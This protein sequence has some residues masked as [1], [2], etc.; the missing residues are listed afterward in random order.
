MRFSLALVTGA[1]SGIGEA[2]AYLLANKGIDLILH[3]RNTESLERV[4]KQIGGKVKVEWMTAD[5]AHSDERQKVAEV[6]R[7]KKP[8]LVINNAGFGLFGS[9]LESDVARQF[10]IAEVNAM[11]VL[12]L[13]LVAA[14]MMKGAELQGV[15]LNVSSSA[16]ELPI[17]PGFAVYSA[18]KAFVNKFS[19]SLD[20]EL[21]GSGIRVLASAPG[22]VNTNFSK[23]AG[24]NTRK[25]IHNITMTSDFAAAQIWDQIEKGKPLHLFDWKTRFLISFSKLFPKNWVGTVMREFNRGRSQQS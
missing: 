23:R 7:A 13:T 24:S 15:I 1:S 6:I 21:K 9:A 12:E 10:E 11:A 22:F 2:L 4:K 25:E 20:F 3:G 18:S 17:S 5:L 19:Q 14:Q 16:G 8:N